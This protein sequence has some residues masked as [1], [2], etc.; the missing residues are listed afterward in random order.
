MILRILRL[1]TILLTP[2]LTLVAL[3]RGLAPA[4]PAREQIVFSATFDDIPAL[5]MFDA[6]RGLLHRLADHVAQVVPDQ[7]SWSADGQLLAYIFASPAAEDA[8]SLYI[9]SFVNGTT[10]QVLEG[11][12]GDLILQTPI[13]SQN[14]Q[15]ILYTFAQ[16]NNLNPSSVQLVRVGIPNAPAVL[17][18]LPA[19]EANNHAL[20]WL[21]SQTLRYVEVTRQ[22]VVVQD[23]TLANYQAETLQAWDIDLVSWWQP[24][25]S[26]DGERILIPGLGDGIRTFDIYRFDIANPQ[27]VNITGVTTS[28]ETQPAWSHDGERIAYKLLSEYQFIMV[29]NADGSDSQVLYEHRTAR[30]SDIRWSPDDRYIAFTANE[31]QRVEMCIIEVATGALRCPLAGRDIEELAWRPG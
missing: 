3:T 22:G 18:D 31:A 21:P 17:G 24:V 19:A 5:F 9:H 14:A 11:E 15:E 23:I 6:E 28:N 4:L 25:F 10:Q 26:P 16:A 30:L 8:E 12:T 1:I 13:W 27:V 7:P 29:A 20:V 2:L